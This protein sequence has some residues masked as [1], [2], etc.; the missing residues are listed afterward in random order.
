M[1]RIYKILYIW[2]FSSS[3]AWAYKLNNNQSPILWRKEEFLQL[4]LNFYVY[5]S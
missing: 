5:F 1:I 3:L 4:F 2:L